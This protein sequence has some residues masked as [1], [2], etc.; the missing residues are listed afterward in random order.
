[1]VFKSI[2]VNLYNEEVAHAPEFLG[3]CDIE[4]C[5]AIDICDGIAVLGLLGH[6][7]TLLGVERY[8]GEC[9]LVSLGEIALVEVAF[10]YLGLAEE[11]G[12]EDMVVFKLVLG[13]DGIVAGVELLGESVACLL[14]DFTFALFGSHS[15]IE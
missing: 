5:R 6:H 10:H 11:S 1:M 3:I 12:L 4:H 8:L 15:S 2:L 9:T 14:S 7:F 13:A